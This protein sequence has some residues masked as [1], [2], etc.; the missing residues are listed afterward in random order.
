MPNTKFRC[1]IVLVCLL[2][3]MAALP[4][5]AAE[6]DFSGLGTASGGFKPQGSRFLVSDKFTQDLSSMYYFEPAL[7]TVTGMVIKADGANLASFDFLDLSIRSPFGARTFSVNITATLKAGGTVSDSVVSQLLVSSTKTALTTLGMDFSAFKDVTGLSIDLTVDGSAVW[8]INFDTITIENE[9]AP[10]I[11]GTTPTVQATN[12]AP[13]SQGTSGINI[14][15]QNGDGSKRIV[16][17]KQGNTGTPTLVDHTTYTAN[18]D[19]SAAADIG[20]GWKCVLKGTGQVAAITGLTA[21]TEYRMVVYEFDGPAG[22]EAYLTTIGTNAINHF[23]SPAGIDKKDFSG[24]GTASGGFKPQGGRYLVSDKFL[25]DGTSMFYD[26]TSTAVTGMVIKPNGTTLLSFDLTDMEI[27]PFGVDRVITITVTA[28]LKAGGS[29]SQT[30]TGFTLYHGIPYSL[31]LMGMD[32][33]AFDDVTQLRIDLS[34]PQAWLINFDNITISDPD[35]FLAGTEPTTQATG[36]KVASTRAN[37]INAYWQ[38]GDGSNRVVFARAGNTGTPAVTDGVTYMA[39]ANF[40]AATDIGGGWKCVYQGP[41]RFVSLSGLTA[42]TEYRLVVYEFNGSGGGENY[43]LTTGTNIINHA[44]DPTDLARYDFSGLGT[45]SGGFKPQGNRFLVSSSFAQDGTKMYY[46]SGASTVTGIVIKPDGT[47]L[48]SLDLMDMEF[49]PFASDRQVSITVT[50][51]LAGGGTTSQTLPNF[52]MIRNMPFSLALLG[53]DFS[54]FTGVTELRFDITVT[55]SIVAFLNFENITLRPFSVI[56]DGNGSTGGVVPVDGADYFHGSTATVLGNTGGLTNTGFDFTGWNTAADGSGAGYVGGD[57]F[58]MNAGDATLYAQWA[59]STLTLTYTAGT[60]GYLTGVT[61]QTVNYGADG[62]PVTAWP[63]T[64][65]LFLR[66]TDGVLSASRTDTNVTADISAMAFFV[67]NSYTLT[68]T[69]G[70]HGTIDGV[71]PQTVTYGANGT[72]VTAIPDPGY[73]F[74]Q[75][76]DGS[77]NN[78][79]VD[80]NV[81]ANIAVTASFER[82]LS[83]FTLD[84]TAGDHGSIAGESPQTVAQG[85]D[86]APVTAVPDAGY[87]FDKWSDG[88]ATATR[89]DTN[90]LSDIAVTATFVVSW[91][92]NEDLPAD[93]DLD[94]NGIPDREQ[95]NIRV[96]SDGNGLYIGFIIPEDIVLEYLE[97]VDAAT[98][99]DTTN[100]PDAFPLGLVRFRLLTALPGETVS[101]SIYCSQPIPEGAVWYKHDPAVGWYD[102]S[103]HAVISEDRLSLTLSCQDGGFGDLDGLVNGII[104]DPSGP[105]IFFDDNG[106]HGGGSGGCFLD[107][108]SR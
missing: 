104:E 1:L 29:T 89:T 91:M 6:Y 61:P 82:G 54:A 19:F 97:W 44:T 40:S 56:Y 18:A 84:Y 87:R 62:T 63:Q 67:P 103:A 83:F 95:T 28:D 33:S 69:A 105:A 12:L 31:D 34:G 7:S 88:V 51:V 23:T 48:L 101:L 65:Y 75:W 20:G 93:L 98:V 78:P 26:S 70:P 9:Q 22:G 71:T 17:A 11:P 30:V 16:F 10:I 37:T 72:A 79:R 50:G 57:T 92:P 53:L 49:S 41:E 85:T 38:N 77:R 32:F 14:Y 96:V 102:Y 81:T 47:H 25:N 73:Y 76:S 68:Y 80:G 8:D 5:L 52:T 55:A 66:W 13:A 90:V 106:H 42:D 35:E 36:L 108:A 3:T 43:L 58:I 107:T 74:T 60:G 94:G 39:D 45:A 46:N 64:G 24:L 2:M 100:R 86:G 4:A 99:P 27:S 59:I 15:W 21:G